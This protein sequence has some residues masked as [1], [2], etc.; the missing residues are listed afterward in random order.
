[1]EGGSKRQDAVPEPATAT[2]A[3][4]A[5]Q[6]ARA[7]GRCRPHHAAAQQTHQ[8]RAF[9]RKVG[10]PV[11]ESNHPQRHTDNQRRRHEQHQLQLLIRVALLSEQHAPKGI[12]AGQQRS[13]GRGHA[14]FEQQR[15]QQILG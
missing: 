6:P 7:G 14:H 10:E 8:E 3:Q 2:S 1:V 15:E 5:I 4:P 13:E 11:G 12:P 9:Q